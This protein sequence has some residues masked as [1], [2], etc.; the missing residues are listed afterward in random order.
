[1]MFN[2]FL[3]VLFLKLYSDDFA[4]LL[5]YASI[6]E[7]KFIYKNRSFIRQT[8]FKLLGQCLK[9]FNRGCKIIAFISF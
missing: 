2:R 3:G 9:A 7:S 5:R 1:M 8:I 4:N 6:I